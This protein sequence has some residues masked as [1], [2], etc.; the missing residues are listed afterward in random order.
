MT[1][2][3]GFIDACEREAL[4]YCG[5]IQ[6]HG[7]LLI[8]DRQ[9]CV[10]QV[11]ANIEAWLKVP[12]PHLLGQPL[13]APLAEAVS[14][15]GATAGARQAARL[16]RGAHGECLLSAVRGE[17]GEQ[18][19]KLLPAGI[20]DD[21]RLPASL[22]GRRRVQAF[23]DEHALEQAR[24]TLLQH[25]LSASGFDRVLYYRFLLEGDGEVL[26]EVRAE[27]ITGS[28]LGL[29]FPASDIPQV[30][31]T[32]YVRNPW[33]SIPDAE[34][35]DIALLG[36]DGVSADLSLT[37]LRGLSPVHRLYMGNMGVRAAVSFPL[38]AAHTLSGLSGWLCQEFEADGLMVD[39]GQHLYSAGVCLEPDAL[40]AVCHWCDEPGQGSTRVTESLRRDCPGIPLSVVAGV[41]A[42]REAL[43]PG[44]FLRVLLCR[45][46]EVQQVAWGGNPDK[47]VE[48]IGGASAIAPRRSFERWVE[49]RLGYSRPWPSHAELRLLKLRGLM[50]RLLGEVAA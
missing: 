29:R 24:T 10:T 11:S 43:G 2:T 48:I 17:C 47:P 33:R 36:V 21:A 3:H 26:G 42:S 7:A 28:Y 14:A 12:A 32:L 4:Q 38:L 34:A 1:Q 16:F 39:D 49:R 40:R 9:G 22:G 5:C 20:D 18:L 41:L 23:A 35:A 27:G 45:S 15:L 44:R 19:I 46:E 50:R 30:A 13:P 37:D 31:R 25:L 6:G 8:A